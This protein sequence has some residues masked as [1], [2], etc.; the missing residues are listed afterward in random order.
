MEERGMIGGASI[1]DRWKTDEG[2]V[3]KPRM[4]MWR[5]VRTKIQPRG[6]GGGLESKNLSAGR[7]GS[8]R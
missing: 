5:R 2:E 7:D 8:R 1:R 3:K 4:G 6:G